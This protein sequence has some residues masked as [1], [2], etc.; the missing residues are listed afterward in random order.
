[1]QASQNW[2]SLPDGTHVGQTE[3]ERD[4]KKEIFLENLRAEMLQNFE[5]LAAGLNEKHDKKA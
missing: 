2:L 1:M 5:K 3:E 4:T